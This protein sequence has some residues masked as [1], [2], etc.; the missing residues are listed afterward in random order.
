MNVA[1]V[2]YQA[3]Q[4]REDPS[5]KATADFSTLDLILL[6]LNLPTRARIAV[7]APPEQ[8][9]VRL[10]DNSNAEYHVFEDR[11]HELRQYQ[12]VARQLPSLSVAAL[13][14]LNFT[15]RAFD[16]VLCFDNLRS[17]IAHPGWA[18]KISDRIKSLGYFVYASN[19]D[20]MPPSAGDEMELYHRRAENWLQNRFNL[21]GIYQESIYGPASTPVNYMSQVKAKSSLT[22]TIWNLS[23][24]S[25]GPVANRLSRNDYT[26]YQRNC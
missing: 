11:Q 24:L 13:V 23:R 10:L 19:L 21:Q 1:D 26:V 7:I 2:S 3:F 18:E 4:G 14:G 8:L 15:A 17:F 25:E 12:K 9:L 16:L 5:A 20:L 6:S 22:R